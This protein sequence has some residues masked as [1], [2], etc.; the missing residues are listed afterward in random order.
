MNIPY[1]KVNAILVFQYYV[2]ML[3]HKSALTVVSSQQNKIKQR[4]IPKESQAR[5]TKS[6]AGSV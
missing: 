5:Q 1:L 6:V 2:V 3:V 4:K